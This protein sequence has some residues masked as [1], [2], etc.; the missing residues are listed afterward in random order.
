MSC[1][2]LGGS[3][4]LLLWKC[5]LFFKDELRIIGVRD[6]GGALGLLGGVNDAI[7]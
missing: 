5:A 3:I 4:V 6:P 1:L 7:W 2:N